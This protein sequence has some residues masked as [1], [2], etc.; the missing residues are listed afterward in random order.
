MKNLSQN[1]AA[2]LGLALIG[3]VLLII[4]QTSLVRESGM[5]AAAGIVTLMIGALRLADLTSP[6]RSNSD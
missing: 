5:L 3:A 6:Y 1:T 2:L 4:G